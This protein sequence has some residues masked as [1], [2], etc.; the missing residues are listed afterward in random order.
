MDTYMKKYYEKNKEEYQIYMRDYQAALQELKDAPKFRSYIE[1]ILEDNHICNVCGITF[2]Q[3]EVLKMKEYK[4]NYQKKY[5]SKS[6]KYSD[7]Q[8]AYKKKKRNE[9]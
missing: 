3:L 9:K 6:S 8:K 2:K 7:Y 5:R 1:Q 4:N